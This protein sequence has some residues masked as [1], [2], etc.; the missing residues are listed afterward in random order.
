[1]AALVWR[2]CGSVPEN[3]SKQ[4]RGLFPLPSPCGPIRS[5]A[6][7][8]LERPGLEFQHQTRSQQYNAMGGRREREGGKKSAIWG[9]IRGGGEEIDTRE[10]E[11]QIES[12]EGK[13][14]AVERKRMR[15]R[16][17]VWL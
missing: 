9:V 14:C 5:E 12:E 8:C 13:F 1:M 17:A 6:G 10:G 2:I 15:E 4:A 3:T 16:G 11:N 7:C